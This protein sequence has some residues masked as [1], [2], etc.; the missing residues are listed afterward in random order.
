MS[1]RDTL[2]RKVSIVV[3]RSILSGPMAATEFQQES[4]IF[5]RFYSSSDSSAE[6]EFIS[7]LYIH[8]EIITLFSPTVMSN[9]WL[10]WWK[11]TGAYSYVI[12][13]PFNINTLNLKKKREVSRVMDRGYR[14]EGD[15]KRYVRWSD[16]SGTGG[17]R[18]VNSVYNS[19]S[20]KLL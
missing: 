18:L 7:V 9:L 12:N 10:V 11:R 19:M 3:F 20:F 2:N 13:S 1:V 15:M 4:D 8:M 6:C 14:F 16:D 5:I 17:T